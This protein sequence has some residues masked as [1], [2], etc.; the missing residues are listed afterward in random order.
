LAGAPGKERKKP[1]GGANWPPESPSPVV[2][3]QRLVWLENQGGL[4]RRAFLTTRGCQKSILSHLLTHYDRVPRVC[5]HL[6]ILPFCEQPAEQRVN[7][8]QQVLLVETCGGNHTLGN[9]KEK[10][11]QN[12]DRRTSAL[13]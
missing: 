5:G 7:K 6:V 11:K 10:D 3:R 1:W 2:C 9:T 13:F 12:A 4:N 8:K